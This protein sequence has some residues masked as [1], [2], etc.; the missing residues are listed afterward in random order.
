MNSQKQ[1]GARCIARMRGV[2]ER[3][4][5]AMGLPGGRAAYLDRRLA[6]GHKRIGCATPTL[7][8]LREAQE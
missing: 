2:F 8:R 3:T 5:K 6:S 7:K 4:V 1:I